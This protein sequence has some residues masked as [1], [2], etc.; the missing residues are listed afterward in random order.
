MIRMHKTTKYQKTVDD[1]KFICNNCGAESRYYTNENSMKLWRKL[2]FKVN[3]DCK[4][5]Y[6][7]KSFTLTKNISPGTRA[8]IT[9]HK[10][11]LN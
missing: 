6:N 5:H 3:P 8:Y 11:I 1:C 2:H 10:K 9:R 4:E 7:K